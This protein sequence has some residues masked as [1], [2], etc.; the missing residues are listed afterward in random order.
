MC[1]SF[2][3]D[4]QSSWGGDNGAVFQL[5]GEAAQPQEDGGHSEGLGRGDGDAAQRKAVPKV[6]HGGL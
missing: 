1:L 2:L 5:C 6:G 4:V 3:G